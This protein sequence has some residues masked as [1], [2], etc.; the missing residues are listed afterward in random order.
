MNIPMPPIEITRVQTPA[1]RAARIEQRD[2]AWGTYRRPSS[3]SRTAYGTTNRQG[4]KPYV[5]PNQK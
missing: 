3:Q 5:Y 1:G 2:R 4:T